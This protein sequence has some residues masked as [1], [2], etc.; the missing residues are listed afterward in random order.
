MITPTLNIGTPGCTHPAAYPFC[1][2]HQPQFLNTAKK[3]KTRFVISVTTS[4]RVTEL[5]GDP[6]M[7]DAIFSVQGFVL[8]RTSISRSGVWCRKYHEVNWTDDCQPFGAG[9]IF[10]ILAHSVYKMWIIQ[11]PNKLE[12]WNKL[13]FK[14]K[15]KNGEYTPCLKYSV[16]IFVE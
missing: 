1:T 2:I 3:K 13:H 4:K 8:P 5:P 11:K 9:I 6:R 16:P 14:E 7:R 10:L 12:L 15:K